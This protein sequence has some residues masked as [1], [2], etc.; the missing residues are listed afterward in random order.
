MTEIHQKVQI[1][2][3]QKGLSQRQLSQIA[4]MPQSYLSKVESGQV[5]L[6]LSSLQAIT[7]ALDIEL[8]LVPKLYQPAVD[9]ILTGQATQ[10]PRWQLDEFEDD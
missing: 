6:R 10:T 1:I 5:D 8:M 4:G 9:A 7:T 2:R 3:K